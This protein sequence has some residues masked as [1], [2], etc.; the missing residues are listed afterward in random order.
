MV[1]RF[2]TSALPVIDADDTTSAGSFNKSGL[3]INSEPSDKDKADPELYTT[4][5]S[6]QDI[7][8]NPGDGALVVEVLLYLNKDVNYFVNTFFSEG[9]A[10]TLVLK[11]IHPE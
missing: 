8:E 10:D 3:A 2:K 9:M 6:Y 1:N 4:A 7:L 5:P 11:T